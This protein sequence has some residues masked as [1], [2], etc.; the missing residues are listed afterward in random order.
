MY[1]NTKCVISEL[2][3]EKIKEIGDYK[4]QKE[5]AK[6]LENFMFYCNHN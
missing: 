4:K 6:V 2:L 1:H 3:T 5:Y